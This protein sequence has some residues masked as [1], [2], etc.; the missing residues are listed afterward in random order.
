MRTLWF[1][2]VI[3]LCTT[4]FSNDFGPWSLDPRHPVTLDVSS[5]K[6]G[7]LTAGSQQ[8]NP[9]E[10]AFRFYA[11]WITPIDGKRCSHRP[12]CGE[13]ARQAIQRHGL[14]LGTWMALGRVM[15]GARSSVLRVLPVVED[16][17]GVYFFDP[18]YPST[19]GR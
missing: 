7:S 10:L 4:A 14:I 2:A 9:L 6:R 13:Y 8:A 5:P 18:V 19:S 15:R 16:A 12:S 1:G 17:T 3:G 11:S